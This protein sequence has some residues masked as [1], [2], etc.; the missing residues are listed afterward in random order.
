MKIK[1][2]CGLKKMTLKSM[3]KIVKIVSKPKFICEKCARVSKDESIFATLVRLKKFNVT[4]RVA[5]LYSLYEHPHLPSIK[6]IV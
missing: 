2:L 6:F 4:N 5:P 1:K 3:Q